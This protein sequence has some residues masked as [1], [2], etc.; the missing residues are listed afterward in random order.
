MQGTLV[1][2]N[3]IHLLP[4]E[5]KMKILESLPGVDIAR[6]SCV[7]SEFRN[8]A[9]YNQLWKQKCLGE[10]ANSVIEQT[11]FLFDFVGWKPKFVECWR[12]RRQ[13]VFW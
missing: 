13:R 6:V 11:E 2:E 3:L 1:R 4:T 9:S 5:L 8:L 12:Q 7:D 10:F